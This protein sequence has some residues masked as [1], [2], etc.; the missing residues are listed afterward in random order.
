MA[1][2]IKTKYLAATDRKPARVKA[3]L[4][5]YPESVTISADGRQSHI[6]A[7]RQ[8]AEKIRWKGRFYG[9]VISEDTMGWTL[10]SGDAFELG[11]AYIK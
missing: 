7:A 3:T 8:L 11:D 6:E 2:I 1:R 4:H 5:N 10:V 9:G